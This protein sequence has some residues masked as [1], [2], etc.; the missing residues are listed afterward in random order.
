[1]VFKRPIF[2]DTYWVKRLLALICIALGLFSLDFQVANASPSLSSCLSGTGS[3]YLTS[4]SLIIT[5]NLEITC[6]ITDNKGLYETFTQAIDPYGFPVFEISEE[7]FLSS[8]CHSDYYLEGALM[9]QGSSGGTVTCT[10]PLALTSRY[11]STRSTLHIFVD[12]G[13]ELFIQVPHP[14][15]PNPSNS[16]GSSNSS[17]NKSCS[18]V[19]SSPTVQ[20]TP[21][22]AT[23]GPTFTVT[24]SSSGQPITDIEYAYAFYNGSTKTWGPWLDPL[25]VVPAVLG[26]SVSFTPVSS[27]PSTRVT[28]NA[29]T[30]NSCG[31]SA[32]TWDSDTHT[33]QPFFVLP[34]QDLTLNYVGTFQVGTSGTTLKSIFTEGIPAPLSG[35]S[36][37]PGICSID[38]SGNIT[39]ISPGNCVLDVKSE[40]SP[41]VA[42]GE[43]IFTLNVVSSPQPTTTS[44]AGTSLLNQLLSQPIPSPTLSALDDS[45]KAWL[46]GTDVYSFGCLTASNNKTQPFLQV[47]EGGKWVSVAKGTL[48]KNQT[49]CPNS[50]QIMAI[51][52]WKLNVK[53]T[54]DPTAPP[55]Q[56][57]YVRQYLPRNGKWSPNAFYGQP[58][59]KEM[60]ASR[61]DQISTYLGSIPTV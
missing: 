54:P 61:I 8:A 5:V 41:N 12:I 33:G 48:S 16:G 50:G 42:A 26:G 3:G 51:Y 23:S 4:T 30:F 34:S 6:T 17:T 43:G 55:S 9:M 28:V 47:K 46:F 13:N 35:V 15:I 60:F 57:L 20:V 38:V 31:V 44:D 14:P 25:V 7:N 29:F 22:T 39:F 21:A 11:G 19:P 2:L 49:N 53:G 52:H 58:I 1:M 24:A 18:G 59:Q 56:L 27:P 10:I 32:V 36:S 40:Q 45:N 37:T